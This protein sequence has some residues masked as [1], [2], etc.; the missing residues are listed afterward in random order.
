VP[1]EIRDEAAQQRHR[2]RRDE[3]VHEALA[4]HEL[5]CEQRHEHTSDEGDDGERE[6]HRRDVREQSIA[7]ERVGELRGGGVGLEEREE[8][9]EPE[10]RRGE[11]RAARGPPVAEVP[12]AGHGGRGE[13]D[14]PERGDDR[15]DSEREDADVRAGG[16]VDEA[17]RDAGEAK[18]LAREDDE[19][20]HGEGHGQA[21]RRAHGQGP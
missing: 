8:E 4:C 19:H 15:R 1:L 20:R 6:R 12:E 21:A 3:A 7:R 11:L 9:R 16:A 10:G 18:V 14:E 5:G 17:L 2:H 13:L